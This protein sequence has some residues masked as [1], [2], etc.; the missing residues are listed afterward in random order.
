MPRPEERQKSGA[1]PLLLSPNIIA[2]HPL[3]EVGPWRCARLIHKKKLDS[4][5]RG[6]DKWVR[7]FGRTLRNSQFAAT[8]L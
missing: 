2:V 5:L 8:N 4:R 1:V 3:T 6:N 7:V